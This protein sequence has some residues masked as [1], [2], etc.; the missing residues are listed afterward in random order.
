[1]VWGPE[2]KLASC[3]ASIEEGRREERG[4]SVYMKLLDFRFGLVAVVAVASGLLLAHGARAQYGAGAAAQ[5]PSASSSASETPRLSNEKPDLSGMWNGGRGN[6]GGGGPDDAPKADCASQPAGICGDV[7]A[8]IG[9]RRCAPNQSPCDPQTN[10]TLDGEFSNRLSPNRPL[11]KPE[12]WQKVQDLDYD[13]DTKDPIMQCQSLGLP[14]I[15]PPV[16]IMATPN[17]VVFFYSGEFRIIPTDGR[18]H[19]KERV[20]DIS[21]D[22]DSVGKWEGDTLVIDSLG[23]NDISW[24]A[25]GGYFHSDLMH[26]IEK[27]HRDG[28]TL[29]YDVTVDDPQVLLHPWV[30]DQ[31]VLKLNPN[32]KATILEQAP[33]RDTD[34]GNV[35]IRIRH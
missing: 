35:S 28:N 10:Q 3:W 13:T 14:R 4:M 26:V 8:V 17:E 22:G 25:H 18:P 7:K 33:C 29:T 1:M 12:Y 21:F 2:R 34:L 32:P 11:Y 31:R 19:E 20:E 5:K 16:K 15:G 27:L 30:M 23:F 6:A 24:L 9:S